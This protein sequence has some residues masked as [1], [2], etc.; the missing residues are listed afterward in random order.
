MRIDDG[1]LE[2]TAY[3]SCINL[4]KGIYY[5]TTYGNGRV[6]AIDMRKCNLG[7]DG[8]EIFPLAKEMVIH[9]QN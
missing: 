5:Y 7:G 8:L 6:S 9:R 4:S 3:T 2:M 1:S